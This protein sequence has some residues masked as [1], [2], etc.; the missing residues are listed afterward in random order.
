M[1]SL[2]LASALLAWPLSASAH[3]H[4]LTPQARTDS[5]TLDQKDQH[6]GV[7]GQTRTTN[8]VTTYKPGETVM[9]TWM[10]PINHPGWFRIALQPNGDIFP[11]P[12]A[13]T[14]QAIVMGVAQASNMPTEDLTGMTDPTTGAIILKDRI[15]DGTLMTQI[16]MPNMECA[17]CTL[18]FI[19][20]MIDKPQYTIDPASDDIYFNCADIVLSA[21]APGV[22][23]GNTEPDAPDGNGNNNPTTTGGCSTGGGAGLLVGFALLGLVI[24]R[25]R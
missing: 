4:L 24:K 10:E 22:D 5:Q 23:A 15:A 12:P 7:T 11:I 20:V 6:C 1:R 19:Q 9:V 14:G 8:R 17:N 2:L 18:Q 25:R 21:G 16:T 3:I 13:S